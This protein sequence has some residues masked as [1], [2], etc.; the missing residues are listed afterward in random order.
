[1]GLLVPLAAL[2]LA[3]SW[4]L[5][6]VAVR[7][8]RTVSGGVRVYTGGAF[9]CIGLVW[10]SF[11]LGYVGGY[12]LYDTE[13]FLSLIDTKSFN[14]VIWFACVGIIKAT[15]PDWFRPESELAADGIV[16]SA[17]SD[18]AAPMSP[19]HNADSKDTPDQWR[20]ARLIHCSR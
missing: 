9:I 13:R 15:I 18:R 3:L 5:A 8:A 20:S 12:F 1:M 10:A 17:S 14:F 7:R 16:S 11:W 2:M 4:P 19:Q 6:S